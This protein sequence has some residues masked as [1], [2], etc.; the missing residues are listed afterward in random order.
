MAAVLKFWMLFD[1]DQIFQ[2][3]IP[4]LDSA[5]ISLI[6]MCSDEFSIFIGEILV[7]FRPHFG[8]HEFC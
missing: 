1:L 6:E 8:G 7:N 2:S 5:T 4:I 3:V